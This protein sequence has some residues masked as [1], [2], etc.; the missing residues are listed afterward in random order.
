MEWLQKPT[1]LRSI[2]GPCPGRE[3]WAFDYHQI[4]LAIF[5]ICSGDEKMIKAVYDG[6]DF[7]T[8]MAR[9]IFDL[10]PDADPTESQRGVAKTVNFAFIFGAQENKLNTSSGVQGLY[11]ILQNV[12]PKAIDYLQRTEW[13][14]RRHGFVTTRGGYRLYVPETTP[15]AGVNYIVQGTEGE[16]VKCAQYGIQ[17]YFDRNIF[18]SSDMY[19]TMYIHDELLFDAKQ[20]YGR[21]HITRI[22]KIMNDAAKRYGIPT[23]A[24]C[25]YIANNWSEGKK[26]EFRKCSSRS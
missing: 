7:H 6:E 15:Y 21:N 19:M 13:E 25:K 2:F 14:V 18:P 23:S 26:I 11:K 5:A 4:Q 24:E 10:E 16:I 9:S 8:F 3:W 22:V 12:F 20:G 17:S 1:S